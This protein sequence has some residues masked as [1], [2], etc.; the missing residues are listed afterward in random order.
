MNLDSP[1][2]LLALPFAVAAPFLKA[3]ALRYPVGALV[4][5]LRPSPWRHL[6]LVPRLS[7]AAGL[8]CAV[9]AAAGPLD[10]E[11][12][13]LDPQPGVDVVL[14]LDVSSSMSTQAEGGVEARLEVAK[15]AIASFAARRGGD[16][17]AL[18]TFALYPR[19]VVPLSRDR[20]AL[21]TALSV[22]RTVRIG[23]EEDQTSIGVALGAAAVR[24]A[25]SPAA[26]KVVVL[27][28][29]GEQQVA[30]AGL[31]EVSMLE[32]ADYLVG[33]GIRLH[34]I[35]AGSLARSATAKLDA[36]AKITGGRGFVARDAAAMDRVWTEIDALEGRDEA[37]RRIVVE[38]PAHAPWLALAALLLLAG[39]AARGFVTRTVP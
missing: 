31:P 26:S 4:A 33:S 15:D 18:M 16:R 24:L 11:S 39:T 8:A 14:L 17:L 35:A 27:I 32:A 10:G 5:S 6:G 9:I 2:L 28:T 7:F 3:T 23:S 36:A 29:D 38:S 21:L 34:A 22:V 1:L 13:V 19:L 12:V 30:A 20:D 25:E 37:P